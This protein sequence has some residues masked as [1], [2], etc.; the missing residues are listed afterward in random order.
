MPTTQLDALL[1]ARLRRGHGG[2][3]AERTGTMLLDAGM[4]GRWTIELNRGRATLRRGTVPHPSTT[5]RATPEVLAGVV[6]GAVSGAEAFLAGHLT[7]R[8]DLSLALALDG[9]FET[10]LRPRSQPRLETAYP[11]GVH[12]AYLEAGEPD[13]Q[14]V[15]MLHGLGA[16]SASLLPLV[17]GLGRD[18]RVIAPDMPGFGAT[19]APMWKYT[20]EELAR[21]ASAL[22]DELGISSAVVVGNSLGGRVALEMA[23]QDPERVE[24]L[25]LLCPSPAFRRLRLLVPAARLLHPSIARLPL[26]IPPHE[27]VVGAIRLMF[28]EPTRLPRA[29]YDAGADEFRRVTAQPRHRRAFF[30][31]LRQIYVEEAF[32]DRGFWERLPAVQARALFIWGARDRLVPAGFARHVSTALPHSRSVVLDDCGH[33]PQFELPEQTETLVR[34]LIAEVTGARKVS[35][36]SRGAAQGRAGAAG[37]DAARGRRAPSRRASGSP[38]D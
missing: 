12:T 30:A 36:R 33:V 25:A 1:V 16:T 8:G 6:E 3:L 2:P 13:A 34:E 38:A 22:C 4:A 27:A 10:P 17:I 35:G 7:V 26:P 20:P 9:A 19:D 21:W 32:G 11:M 18:H 5:V 24:G 14:P 28:A 23:L 37:Q 29:W 15:L 31:C